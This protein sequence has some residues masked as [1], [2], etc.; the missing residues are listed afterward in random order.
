MK[1]SN[2]SSDW[3]AEIM[4]NI[5]IEEMK[6]E[7]WKMKGTYDCIKRNIVPKYQRIYQIKFPIRKGRIKFYGS[8]L[9]GW[10]IE[11]FYLMKM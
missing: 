9:Y 3:I 8:C 4:T 10:V 7:G 2:S 6:V 5:A 1:S 11:Y